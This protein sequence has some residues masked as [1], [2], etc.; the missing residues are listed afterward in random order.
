MQIEIGQLRTLDVL[1]LFARILDDLYRRGVVRSVNNPVA[2]YAEY[3]VCKA[4][5]L[6][7]A[8]K[9]AKG[10]D[11]VD[12]SGRH[13]EIKARRQTKRSK[14]TRFSAIRDLES[15]HFDF[16]VAVLF[17]E[18]FAV[19]RAGLVPFDTVVQ[20]SFRQEH[21]NGWIVPLTDGL[22]SATGVTDIREKLR[23]VQLHQGGV[24]QGG[25]D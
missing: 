19:K 25:G 2:D 6:T 18:D 17:A 10:Y 13:Y 22:W 4:L 1:G 9:S 23:E 8:D 24:Q 5:S 11:A 15:K 3:L 16:L 12:S 21:V 20:I 14:P 7:L